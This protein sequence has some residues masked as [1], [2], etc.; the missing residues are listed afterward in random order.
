MVVSLVGKTTYGK[1]TVQEV[2]D[3]SNGTLI[4]YT[5]E[6]WLTSDGES[7]NDKGVKPDYEINLD[8][9]F[10]K[11]PTQENDNQFQKALELAKE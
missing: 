11:N 8:E 6:E 2:S 9:N 1:G 7:I 4:K 10:K 3:L 5:I